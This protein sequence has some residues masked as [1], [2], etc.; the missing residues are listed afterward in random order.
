MKFDIPR[1]G[2]LEPN[3]PGI[4]V[5]ANREQASNYAELFP[6]WTILAAT[7]FT[8]KAAPTYTALFKEFERVVFWHPA[9][10]IK[11]IKASRW[12]VIRDICLQHHT[13]IEAYGYDGLTQPGDTVAQM[14][15]YLPALFPTVLLPSTEM[16]SHVVWDWRNRK[17]RIGNKVVSKKVQV[18]AP[19]W[20]NTP[21]NIELL[22]STI[23]S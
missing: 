4:M 7:K 18:K 12:K 16:E 5:V 17:R 20:S 6:E 1:N 19:V 9:E 23:N 2:K 13:K 22:K 21:R 8:P 3:P 11:D 14:M 15:I 10:F